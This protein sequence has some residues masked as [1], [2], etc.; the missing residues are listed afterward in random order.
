MCKRHSRQNKAQ[1]QCIQF[2][3]TTIGKIFAKIK[4]H[5]FLF[6]S[7]K[8]KGRR[9]DGNF[10]MATICEILQKL[11]STF[12]WT[13]TNMKESAVSWWQFRDGHKLRNFAKI[14]FD[15]FL[16]AKQHKKAQCYDGN[17]AIATICEILQ[18]TNFDCRKS[19]FSFKILY[20]N[21]K[22]K[23]N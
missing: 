1:F 17:F 4:F 23:A 15:F 10:A 13:S 11:I 22:V 6:L 21:S 8:K 9:R 18:K 14:N 12:F 20:F 3:M 16:N 2:A 19:N 7:K 5:I